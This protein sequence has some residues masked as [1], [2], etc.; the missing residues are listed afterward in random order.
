MGT[1]TFQFVKAWYGR[2]G[3]GRSRCNPALRPSAHQ[4][5]CSVSK[6][7][8]RVSLFQPASSSIVAPASAV[9][10]DLGTTNSTVAVLDP[11]TG[12]AQVIKDGDGFD[13]MPSVVNFDTNGTSVTGRQAV[14]L[15]RL[16][17]DNTFYSVKQFIGRRFEDV[18]LEAR[19]AVAYGMESG[20]G[21]GVVLTCAARARAGR[22]GSGIVL[23]EEV[24]ARVLQGL[25]TET[26][27]Q[28]PERAVIAVPP[29]FSPA[30]RSATE[31]AA[32]LAGCKKQVCLHEPVAAALAFGLQ[33]E[34]YA[35]VLVCDLGGG[36]FDVSLVELGCGSAEVMGVAGDGSLGGDH[37]D[38]RI[39]KLLDLEVQRRG[40]R[41]CFLDRAALAHLTQLARQAKISLT[42]D[43]V[44]EV[45]LSGLAPLSLSDS[46]LLLSR[47]DFEDSTKDLISRLAK[48][49]QLATESAGVQLGGEVSKAEGKWASQWGHYAIDHVVL[50]GGATRMP[51]VQNYIHELTGMNSLNSDK[52]DPDFAVALGAALYAG[53]LDGTV[54]DSIDVID[55]IYVW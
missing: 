32:S 14:A 15:A 34:E 49:I 44:A 45:S 10:V 13:S 7:R 20:A 2:K 21:G 41:S 38:Q 9:G 48:P 36:T 39:V 30:Q 51:S 25:W 52:V 55:G 19:Q 31:L 23:P 37:W 11:L 24:S 6:P 26:L 27:G 35:R 40:G 3:S 29:H 46:T 50:V 47:E 43:P 4:L 53:M 12:H 16:D 17:P 22:V 28:A 5:I 54:K 1:S 8:Q 33:S 18:P 42:N